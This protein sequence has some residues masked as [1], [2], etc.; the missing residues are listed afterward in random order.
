MA[1]QVSI[2]IDIGTHFTRAVCLQDNEQDTGPAIRI[3]GVG[4]AESKGVRHGYI[5][6]IPE[7]AK[8]IRNALK[9]IEKALVGIKMPPVCISVGGVGLSGNIFQS[10]VSLSRTEMEVTD[11]DVA[12]VSDHTRSDMPQAF[13]L[14]RRVLHS[15]PLQYKV[16]GRIIPGKPHGL[17][18]M[19]LES[20]TLFITCLAHHVNDTIEAVENAG[21]EIEDITSSPIARGNLLLTKAEKIA[22]VAL[23]DIGAETL[24][25]AV[26]ENSL[27]ISLEVFGTGSN[28]ITN[29]IAL[30]LK[31]GLPE[32][33]E[34]KKSIGLGR[35]EHPKKKLDDII[36]KRLCIMFELVENHLKKIGK[37]GLLPAG[38]VLSGG[39]AEITHIEAAA[40]VHL[41]LPTRRIEE[42]T[43]N[44]NRGQMK[45]SEWAGA[46]GAAMFSMSN[47]DEES[48][49]LKN[50]IAFGKKAGKN[51]WE[52]IK[53]FLP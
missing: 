44:G 12:K 16:D 38:I 50:G 2:G 41:K 31:V 3:A 28:D 15:F 5:T 34:M 35:T 40:K 6:N 23:V 17:K 21:Y 43:D 22:G 45:T 39:G 4:I 48:F 33:E 27:P 37:N 24:S 18:G 53:Q 42:R 8:S 7:A 52:W 47:E 49:G 11:A 10:S 13:A 20:R 36:H 32:A 1:K 46:Y 30:G 51:V 9:P 19:K 25:V 29:D 26:Y 14:N